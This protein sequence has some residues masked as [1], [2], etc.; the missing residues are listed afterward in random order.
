MEKMW[1][2]PCQAMLFSVA[3]VAELEDVPTTTKTGVSKSPH[4]FVLF[5][6]VVEEHVI[7]LER[8]HRCTA[9]LE[10]CS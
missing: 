9:A 4:R 8:P 2:E 5:L 6:A 3:N 7:G 10:P 1:Q